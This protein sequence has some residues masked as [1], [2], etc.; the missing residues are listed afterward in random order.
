MGNR[1][2]NLYDY[3]TNLFY[4]FAVIALI[5]VI[6]YL[7]NETDGLYIENVYFYRIR[8]FIICVFC[9]LLLN[10][11]LFLNELLVLF[12]RI[13]KYNNEIVNKRPF[14]MKVCICIVSLAVAI[15][16]FL[17]IG[18]IKVEDE[19]LTIKDTLFSKERIINYHDLEQFDLFVAQDDEVYWGKHK[20]ESGYHCYYDVHLGK[21][22][23]VDELIKRINEKSG[24]NLTL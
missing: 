13:F 19:H 14:R 15:L 18:M 4:L 7:P 10:I 6:R 12:K 20:Q 5:V 3:K 21:V 22:Q 1:F 24:R 8:S 23:N 11:R 2:K 9:V 16:Y 17:N